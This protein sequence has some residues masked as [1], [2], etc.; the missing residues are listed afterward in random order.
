MDAADAGHDSCRGRAAPLFIHAPRDISAQLEEFSV[1]V[2][3]QRDA[4]ARS[5][6]AF[7]VLRLDAFLAAALVDDLFFIAQARDQL[8]HGVNVVL[9]AMRT[10]FDFAFECG[11]GSFVAHGGS[12]LEEGQR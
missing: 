12:V 3:Q 4:L 2:D 6:A 7:L 1:F 8:G 10:G 5:E 11:V 9:K